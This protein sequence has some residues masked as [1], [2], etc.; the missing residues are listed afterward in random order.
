MRAW[1]CA[2]ASRGH[3]SFTYFD[4]YLSHLI[5]V[6]Q[7]CNILMTI[8]WFILA[9]FVCCSLHNT[10]DANII[11]SMLPFIHPHSTWYNRMKIW[12]SAKI[13]TI[14]YRSQLSY[15][16]KQNFIDSS[17]VGRKSTMILK[18]S[19]RKAS[20]LKKTQALGAE[21]SQ[22]QAIIPKRLG[23]MIMSGLILSS[24]LSWRVS[25]ACQVS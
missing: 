21:G 20:A 14:C 3:A 16:W 13:T 22:H 1:E 7:K 11:S 17:H 19:H 6:Y 18:L 10:A 8:G 9:A 24:D 15:S 23:Q 12:P 2:C 25:R 5:K 4:I